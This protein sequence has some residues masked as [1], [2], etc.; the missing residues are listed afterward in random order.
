M[1]HVP[2]ADC[3]VPKA[4]LEFLDDDRTKS[5]S[6]KEIMF[7]KQGG[8]EG[9][10]VPLLPARLWNW[11]LGDFFQLQSVFLGGLVQ[12]VALGGFVLLL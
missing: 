2:F 1:Y 4:R 11:Q 7:S 12:L 5:D 9:I 6:G 3:W 8:K 10:G